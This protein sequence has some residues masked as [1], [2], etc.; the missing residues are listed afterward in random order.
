MPT[1]DPARGRTSNRLARLAPVAAA[2][3][4]ALLAPRAQ[5]QSY[6]PASPSVSAPRDD[7]APP[8]AAPGLTF[9]RWQ[10]AAGIRTSVV[11]DAGFDPFSTGDLLPQFS[12]TVMHTL[13]SG[14]G[15]VPALG[16]AG[17]VGSSS[18]N[19]RGAE[20]QLTAW[21]LALV[22]EPRFVFSPGLYLGA[23]VAPG[24]LYTS[25][26]LNDG[27]APAPLS[28]AYSTFSVDAS[29]SGGVRLNPG[30]GPIGLW[31]V[32]DTGYGWAPRRALTLAPE[33]PVRDTNKAGA[34]DLGSLSPRGM[35]GRVSLAV[36]Y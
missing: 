30:M 17:D 27:S 19:A 2:G 21:R 20:A 1:P 14:Q 7:V 16:L 36:S 3:A 24:L 25:A 9:E 22:L 26:T 4:I 6:P 15:F 33:L 32:A 8:P 13:R 18:A 28:T 35:F 11:R 29:L 34:T 12:V 10:V 23:R 31:L 5:A